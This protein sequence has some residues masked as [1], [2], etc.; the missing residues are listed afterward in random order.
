MLN[1]Y[2]GK[3]LFVDLTKGT[4]EEEYLDEKIC[5]DFI[6]GTGLGVRV[7][8]ER[9]T[10]GADPLG[11]GNMLGFVTG[12]LTATGVPGGGRYTVVT[13]SPVTGAWADSNSGGFWGPELKWAGYDAVFFSG[14]SSDPVYL[15]ISH[16]HVELRDASHLWGKDTN[17]TDAMLQKELGEPQCR[18]ACIGPSGESCSLMAGI[19]NERGR[20]AARSGVGAVMGSKRLKAVALQGNI[21][22]KIPAA[23]GETLKSVQKEFVKNLKESPFHQG[24]TAAGTGG[25]TSFLLSIGDCPTKNWATTGTESMP[26]CE[27]LNS[28][29]M[30]PYK[31]KDYGCHACPLRCGALVQV[32]EGAFSTKEEVHRPEYETLAALGAL[33]LN[34]QVEAVIKANEICNLYGLDTIA[35]GGAVAFGMECYEKGLLDK[36]DTGGIE[37]QWGSGKAVVALTEKIAKREGLGAIL[38]DGVK[39]AAEHIGKGSNEFAMHIGGHRL[40]YHDPRM[41]PALGAYYIGDAQPACHTGPQGTNLLETGTPLGSSPSLESPKLELFGDYDRK[42]DMYGTGSAYFQ[43][44]SSAGLCALY[45]IGFAIPVVEL[46]A[47]VTGWDLSWDEG[48]ETGRRILT[49]RQAFNAREGIRPDQFNMPK[50]LLEPLTVGPGAGQKVDF[51][52]LKKGFFEA[53]GWDPKSGKPDPTTWKKL[54]L[55]ELEL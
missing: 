31:L 47:P 55:D 9:M 29:N 40:P 2:A 14:M 1:G 46:L 20:I 42:G 27:N 26:T 45:A 13:K 35:V 52:A 28:S 33:C 43:L 11:E 6:G 50:R 44:L 5:R 24:L 7:L 4:I 37:L 36:N 25:G 48:L 51:P 10:P 34:D 15:Y 54:G 53:M 21:K 38:A 8:Y 17:E 19:V 16:G 49:L 30:D 39:K 12:P 41:A 18:I 22:N 23:D 32:K 3:I